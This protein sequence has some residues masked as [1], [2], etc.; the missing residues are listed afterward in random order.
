AIHPGGS[1]TKGFL[2][3]H[4]VGTQVYDLA[5]A[6]SVVSKAGAVTIPIDESRTMQLTSVASDPV[7]H[8]RHESV[9]V[10]A[11]SMTFKANILHPRTLAINLPVT[12]EA[13]EDSENLAQV[14]EVTIARALAAEIDRA[15]L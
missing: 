5:R 2:L 6:H 4:G 11:T 8:W 13:I 9:P 14:L 1:D 12:I 7:A 3:K 15:A 10:P